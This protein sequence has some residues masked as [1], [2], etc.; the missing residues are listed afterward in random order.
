MLKEYST[1]DWINSPPD[2]VWALLTDAAGYETWNPEILGVVGRFAPGA[3][4]KARVK[5]KAGNGKMAVRMVGMRIT[6]FEPLGAGAR[7]ARMEWTGG[8]PLGLFKGVRILS[9]A[10]GSRGGTDFRMDLKMSGP[11]AG[12]ILKS[13]GDRQ[14][15]IDSFTAG[16]KARAEEG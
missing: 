5:V 12:P 3:K 2:R 7:R 16:L 11:L 1:G 14:P 15:E 4:I 6:A 8:L 10:P 13:I 9:V